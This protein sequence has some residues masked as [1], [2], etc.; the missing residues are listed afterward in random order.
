MAHTKGDWQTVFFKGMNEQEMYVKVSGGACICKI[1]DRPSDEKK[2]NARLIAASPYLLVACKA[3][4]KAANWFGASDTGRKLK[5]E[6][7]ELR[8]I[9]IDKAVKP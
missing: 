9:A 3:Q 5:N 4:E 8:R 1:L 6:A 7:S 2:A